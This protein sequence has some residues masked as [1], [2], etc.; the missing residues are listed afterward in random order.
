N[1]SRGQTS[2]I[3]D[4][5]IRP[6]QPEPPPEKP[7][8]AQ[9]FLIPAP[10]RQSARDM[11]PL[12]RDLILKVWGGEPLQC[13]CCKGTMKPVRKVLRREEIEQRRRLVGVLDRKQRSG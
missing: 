4:R 5:I 3:P 9:I 2:N 12:W 6:S 13:P 11:R 7:P 1:K 8:P 10:P